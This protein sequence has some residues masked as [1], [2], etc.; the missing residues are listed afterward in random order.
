MRRFLWVIGVLFLVFGMATAAGAYTFTLDSYNVTLNDTDPGLVLWWDDIL[1]VPVSFNANEGDVL[2]ADL[3][4]V[5]TQE[6]HINLDDRI[7]FG[8]FVEFIFSSPDVDGVLTGATFGWGQIFGGIGSVVWDNPAVFEFGDGGEF[9][10]S[11]SNVNFGTPG[12]A[13]VEATFEYTSAPQ[14]VP[15]PATMALLCTGLVGLAEE[16]S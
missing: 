5:G 11:L 1:G 8:I 7:P 4:Q 12:S 3:F 10:M 9:L 16:S 2:T 6:E 15:E 14:P 13:T